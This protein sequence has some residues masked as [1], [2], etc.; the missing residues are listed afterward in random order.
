MKYLKIIIIVA[1]LVLIGYLLFSSGFVDIIKDPNKLQEFIEGY[2]IWGYLIFIGVFILVAVFSLPASAVTIVAG[3][4]FGPILGAILALT[5]ATLGAAA[6]FLVSRYLARDFI[7]SKFG[8]N[9]VFKKIE[10]GVEKNGTDFLMIT[11]LVPAFPYNIQNYAYGVTNMGFMKYF[12]ITGI[13][14]APGAFIYAF[15]AGEIATNGMSLQI[16]GYL[17]IAGVVLFTVA[18]I[19]TFIAKKKGIEMD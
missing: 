15:L 8:E 19:P 2:G 14:M 7:I 17:L 13:C 12:V 11:R 10:S 9:A 6:A 16:L 18:K 1:V 3:I 5:G 4:A